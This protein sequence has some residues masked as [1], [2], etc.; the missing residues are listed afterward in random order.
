[1]MVQGLRHSSQD[2]MA[3]V[4]SFIIKEIG[5]EV[6]NYRVKFNDITE[7]ETPGEPKENYTTI[8]TKT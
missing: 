3:K 4:Q 5:I 1:M 8:G 7:G 6:Q 2:L